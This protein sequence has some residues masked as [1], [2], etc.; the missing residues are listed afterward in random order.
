MR[1]V[2]VNVVMAH[3]IHTADDAGLIKRFVGIELKIVLRHTNSKRYFA[4]KHA[5]A[6]SQRKGKRFQVSLNIL[7]KLLTICAHKCYDSG[8]CDT[9]FS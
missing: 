9:E 5:F 3:T 2:F 8:I 1:L 7:R 4:Q 6:S